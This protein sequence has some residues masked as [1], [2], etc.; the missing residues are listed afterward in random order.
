[1]P[2]TASLDKE[3]RQC[4]RECLDCYSICLETVTHCLQMGG[5]HAD[6]SHIAL[7]L[8]CARICETCASAMLLGARQ[9]AETCDACAAICRACAEECRRLGGGDETMQRCA[10]VCERCAESCGRMSSAA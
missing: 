5:K 8:T 2:H 10:E 7:L 9:H 4:I 1:M 6:Q 3:M